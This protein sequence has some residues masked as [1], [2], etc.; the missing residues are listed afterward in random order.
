MRFFFMSCYLFGVKK[1]K[2]N[3]RH[4]YCQTL[5]TPDNNRHR[6]NRRN[7]GSPSSV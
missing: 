4:T 6:L 2:L 7:Y 1:R 5:R 3:N